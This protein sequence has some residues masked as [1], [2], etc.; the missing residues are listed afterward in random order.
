MLGVIWI[1]QGDSTARKAESLLRKSATRWLVLMLHVDINIEL[2]VTQHQHVCNEM[3]SPDS[4][5]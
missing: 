5:T 2:A 1:A 3:L 4:V